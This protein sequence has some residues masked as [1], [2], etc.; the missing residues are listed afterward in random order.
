VIALGHLLV[1][2]L[3]VLTLTLARLHLAGA[4]GG[5]RGVGFAWAVVVGH[6]T[7]LTLLL[8]LTGVLA[9]AGRLPATPFSWSTRPFPALLFVGLS[10]AAAAAAAIAAPTGAVSP[11]SL[12]G[13]MRVFPLL[14]PL[15]L[16]VAAAML[17]LGAPSPVAPSPWPARLLGLVAAHT[18]ALALVL[19]APGLKGM[20]DVQRVIASRG[21]SGLDTFQQQRLDQM[22]TLDPAAHFGSILGDARGGNHRTI[23]EHALELIQSLPDWESRVVAE[24][25]GPNAEAAFAFLASHNVRD[26]ARYAEA[27]TTGIRT[28]A[29]RVRA[30]I[31][32]AS[33]PSHLYEGLMV[34][35]VN[36]L[37]AALTRLSGGGVDYAPA[38]HELRA[39]FAEP[40]PWPHPRYRAV[41]D[42]DRW[43]RK[44]R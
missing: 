22:N 21:P 37:L 9:M 41:S 33:H 15:L 17:L 8:A 34:F 39:A 2:A 25:S 13:L 12:A 18:A 38:L 16:T 6:G 3:G 30:R 31:R 40:A 42:I 24:L 4:P 20:I 11:V 7:V 10:G 27:A 19:A 5:D 43:L 1:L 28:E 35:E 29:E 44:H 14:V 32:N 26:P 23:R 36:E